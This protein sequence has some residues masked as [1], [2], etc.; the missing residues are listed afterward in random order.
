MTT[1]PVTDPTDQPLRLRT[2]HQ[3]SA[4]SSFRF[5][6]HFNQALETTSNVLCT[7]ST[8]Y[9]IPGIIFRAKRRRESPFFLV[10]NSESLRTGE[11]YQL[12]D[13]FA[14]AIFS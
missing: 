5:F 1:K 9:R 2:L 4:I 7:L 8:K 13:E 12:R 3:P 6:S 11:N 10:S 14:R